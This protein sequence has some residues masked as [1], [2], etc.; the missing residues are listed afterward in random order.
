[1]IGN[2][3]CGVHSVMAG[4]TDDNVLD[5]EVVA[6][7]G[8]RLRV[9][10]RRRRISRASSRKAAGARGDLRKLRDLADR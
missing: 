10:P 4:K 1:M 8:T 2:N 6:G 7:D 5:L 9:G 3:S